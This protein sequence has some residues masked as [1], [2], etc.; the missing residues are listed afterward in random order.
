MPV[1]PGKGRRA[2]VSYHCDQCG[3]D[4]C[5]QCVEEEQIAQ[6]SQNDKAC[7]SKCGSH[8]PIRWDADE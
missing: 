3:Y 4:L 7:A 1:A 6:R 2:I 5:T 8:E